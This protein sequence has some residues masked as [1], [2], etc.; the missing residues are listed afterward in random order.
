MLWWDLMIALLRLVAVFRALYILHGLVSR[1]R[2]L[3]LADQQGAEM[4]ANPD[5]RM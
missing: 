1:S 2:S 5:A 4:M 3:R